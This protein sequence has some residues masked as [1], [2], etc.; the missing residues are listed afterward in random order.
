[1]SVFAGR[2]ADTG[3][4]PIPLNGIENVHRACF[5]AVESLRTGQAVKVE[6]GDGALILTAA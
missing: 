5:A 6:E 1:M 4:D 3:R 2:I